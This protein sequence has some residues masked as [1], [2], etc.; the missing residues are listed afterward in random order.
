MGISQVSFR[1]VYGKNALLITLKCSTLLIG[2]NYMERVQTQP[3]DTSFEKIWTILER[4]SDRLDRITQQQEETDRIVKEIGKRFGNFTNSFGEVVEYMI[5]PNLQDK[6]QKFNLDFHIAGKDVK[7][8][9]YKN[10]IKFEVDIFLQNGDFAMLVEIK[11]TLTIS[12]INTHI[13]RLEKMRKYA[14][15]HGDKRTFLGSVAGITIPENAKEYALAQGFYLIEPTGED[16][17]ITPPH[18]KPKEW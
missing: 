8:R 6:F 17:C 13:E 3:I 15:L 12:N 2:D 11:A 4:T 10:D 9:D 14:D 7:F 5:A 18:S 16:F 1:L